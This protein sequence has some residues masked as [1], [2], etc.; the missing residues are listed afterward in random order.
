MRVQLPRIFALLVSIA[1]LAGCR[2]AVIVGPGGVVESNSSAM[3]CPIGTVCT[4]GVVDTDLNETL[5][6]I[7]SP[8][9]HFVRWQAGTDFLCGNLVSATCVLNNTGFAGNSDVEALI[10]SGKKYYVSP[11]FEPDTPG[12]VITNTV[13]A[14][15]GE[16][17]QP[18][19]FQGVAWDQIKVACP[20][21]SCTGSLNG[22]KLDGWK[23]AS[24]AEVASLFNHYA[25]SVVCGP[26]CNGAFVNG[27][28]VQGPALA[29]GFIPNLSTGISLGLGGW[30][31]GSSATT[32]Q[33]WM[34]DATT[35]TFL[36]VG[37]TVPVETNGAW[38]YRSL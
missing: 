16:W 1:L 31:F 34:A 26:T 18:S 38:F 20:T 4:F 9:W 11:V 30:H 28:L 21:G 35:T 10:A 32:S 6:A 12:S 27:G 37:V 5:T 13:V 14:N 24:G 17:A 22:Y 2:V 7:A 23:W 33:A 15:G 36:Y 8:G 3:D 25:G 29:D 19:L